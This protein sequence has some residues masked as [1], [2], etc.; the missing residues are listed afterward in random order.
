[1][2]IILS[3]ILLSKI[4]S[5][6]LMSHF[7]LQNGVRGIMLDMHDYYGDIWLCRGPCTIFTAFV[8]DPLIFLND[9]A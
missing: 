9:Y 8:R 1:M 3:I 5:I 4:F 2:F 6:L 7:L